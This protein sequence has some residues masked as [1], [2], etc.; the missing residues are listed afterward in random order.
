MIL[1]FLPALAFLTIFLVLAGRSDDGE[2]ELLRGP[3]VGALVIWGVV[4]VAGME[5]LSLFHAILQATLAVVWVGAIGVVII[6]GGGTA[7][8]RRGWSRLAAAAHSLRRIEIVFVAS[9]AILLGLL[10]L[11]ALIAPPNNV[12]SLSVH[13]VMVVRWAQNHSLAYNA[14]SLPSQLTRP[15]FAEVAILN[16]RSLFGS[17]RPAALA[18]WFS[19]LGSIVVV[20]GIAARLGARRPGQMVAA[21]YAVSLPLAVLTATNTKNDLVVSLW[22]VCLAYFAVL[23]AR[24]PLTR[25]EALEAGAAIGL[26]LLTKGTF[27]PAA[28]PFVCWLGVNLLR[29]TRLRSA[30]VSLTI[31]VGTA[32]VLNLGYWARNVESFGTPFGTVAGLMR[33]LELDDLLSASGPTPA[34]EPVIEETPQPA[35]EGEAEGEGSDLGKGIGGIRWPLVSRVMSLLTLNTIFP[36]VGAPIRQALS[37]LPAVYEPGFLASLEEGLW[38][39]EDSAGSLLHLALALGASLWALARALKTREWVLAVYVF[40]AWLGWGSLTL[41]TNS[42]QLWGIRYQLGFFLISAAVVGMAASWIRLKALPLAL[43]FLLLLTAIPYTFLN[44]TRPLIGARPRTRSA[45][46][47]VATAT[48]LLFISTP[49]V[50]EQYTQAA[51]MLE[52]SS[53]R[54]IGLVLRPR[55]LEYTLWWLLDAPQSGFHLE[56]LLG[57]Q[58]SGPAQDTDFS[59]CAILCTTCL[60]LTQVDGLPLRYDWGYLRLFAAEGP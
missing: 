60:D 15:P 9:I 50:Q 18:Q 33:A 48:D 39:H 58:T 2:D 3:F 42:I 5:L 29:N 19:L 7:S 56:T 52:Q 22:L 17:D 31:V 16:L 10:L 4:L 25:L 37:R 45:S 57:A 59:P 20:S 32:L 27:Q 26:G 44:N 13:M 30:V 21:A 41:I 11:I 34:G 14:A 36:E 47:L 51:K 53:C 54:E 38:N 6:A 8:L 46:I 55:E 40:V 28:F 24:R 1:I 23:S 49:E 43:A 12:D 35:P